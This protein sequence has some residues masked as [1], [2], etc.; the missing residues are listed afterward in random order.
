MNALWLP[1]V[2][3]GPIAAVTADKPL[4]WLRNGGLEQPAGWYLQN[5]SLADGGHPGKSLRFDGPGGASQEVLVASAQHT[6][7]AAVD[8]QVAGVAAE[9]GKS[10]YAFAA[11]YQLDEDGQLVAFRDFAQALGAQPWQRHSFTFRVDPR[12]VHVSLRCGLHQ[13]TGTACFDNWTLVLGGKPMRLDEVQEIP[14][15]PARPGSAAILS[16]ADLPVRGKPSSPQALAKILQGAGYQTQLLSAEDIADPT[17]FNASR[18]DLLV[19][20]TGP[21]FPAEARLATVDFLRK[22]GNLLTTGGYAFQHL[23]RKVG[24]RWLSEEE[25]AKLRL[26]EALQKQS[27]LPNGGFEKARDLP[28]GGSATD[29]QWRRASDRCTV[30]EEDPKE[31]RFVAKVDL[32][33]DVPDPG[34]HAWLDLP[35]EPGKTYRISG[36]MRTR[37]V[38]GAG[39]AFIAIYQHDAAGKLVEHRDFASTRGTTPWQFYT[40]VFTPKPQVARLH[41]FFG[42]YLAHGTAWFDDIRLVETTGLQFR[43]MNTSTGKPGDGLAVAPTQIGIFDPSFP[44]KR[45][46]KIRTAPD[47]HVLREA[48][49]H[50]PHP[51]PLPQGEGTVSGWAASG[52][53]GYDN[54]RWVP[55]LETFDR[56]GRP[57]GAAGAM[58]LHYNGPFAGSFWAY[59]GA[60]NVDL[61]AETDGPAARGLQQ[62]ARFMLRKTF[63]HNL[64]TDH[65]LYR[66]DE[67]VR[68]AVVVDNHGTQEFRGAVR[69]ELFA[70]DV[71]QAASLPVGNTAASWQLALRAVVRNVVVGPNSTQRVEAVLEKF[72]PRPDVCRL[73]ATLLATASPV[74]QVVVRPSRLHQ[75]AG[76]TPAPQAAGSASSDHGV[77]ID[78]MVS[79]IVFEQPAVLQSGPQLRFRDNYFTLNGRPTFLF[80]SDTYALVYKAACENPWTW[81]QELATARDVGMNLYENLQYQNPGHR[82]TEDD[83]RAF[84]A[85][86]QLAQRSGLVFMPGML[87]GHNVAIGDTALE[88]E[89]RLCREYASRLGSTPGLLWYINGDYQLDAAGRPAEVKTLWNRWLKTEHGTTERLRSRWGAAAVQGELGNLEYPPPNSGRWDDAAAVDRMRLLVWLMRRWN[90]A[91]VAA[92]RQHDREHP[93]TSEYYSF[94]FGGM[95]LVM[96]IDGQDVSNIGYFDRPGADLDGLPLKIRW[97]DLRL[98]GK[99][100]S[101]GEYGVKTHP[102]WSEANGGEGYHIVRSEEEQSQLFL[103]VAHYGLGLGACKIQNWCLRDDPTWVFPWGIFYPNHLVPKDVA[104]AHRNQSVLWRFFRPVFRPETL[105]VCIA[106]QLRLGNDDGLGTRVGYQAFADLLALHYQFNVIDDDHLDKLAPQIKTMILPCPLS[107]R[108][109]AFEKLMGWVKAGGTLFATGDFTHDQYRR[110]TRSDRLKQLAGVELVA[111]NGQAGSRTSAKEAR[112]N[113]PGLGI[114][115]AVVRSPDRTTPPTEGLQGSGDLRSANRRGQETCAER[116]FLGPLTLRPCLRIK[117]LTAEVLGKAS[118]GEPVLVRHALGNGTVYFLTDPIEMAD[119]E[120]TIAARRQL[121]A[122]VLRAASRN[123]RASPLPLTVAPDEPWL[124]V[125][126]QPTARGTV[127]VIYNKKPEPGTATVRISTAAG[128]VTLNT[129]NRWPALAAVTASGAVVAVNA[130]GKASVGGKPLLEGAGLKALLSL[131][132]NDLRTA[133]AILIAPF[134]PGRAGLPRRTEP[135]VALVG[136]FREGRWRTLEQIALDSANPTL[137]IDADRATCLILVCPAAQS[138]RWTDRLTQAML[139]PDQIAGY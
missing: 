51:S 78:A 77:P 100:V 86:A 133:T 66:K 69:F 9:P 1:I 42:F 71:G 98:R 129:R 13:A 6:L 38:N 131:D 122:A 72:A 102:A 96:S 37:D 94:P 116:V 25:L 56:Y 48:V 58:L 82:M 23:V 15:R 35:A 67:P 99:G 61:W 29:G 106:N 10:G 54:A 53:V 89:S 105:A 80:G 57:R 68:A 139:R 136:E 117:P 76:E 113:F 40:H 75:T 121:Y 50:S 52:L 83:W 34:A 135:S 43:P 24:D 14:P 4:S 119:D 2:L 125:M 11:V 30:V 124:H 20:P 17:V 62:I 49:E 16:H 115:R 12:T 138:Q 111:A 104:Y 45:A 7:T 36:W 123:H 137:E 39:I 132:G 130:Y 59:F 81:H 63:L 134:E 85:M 128:P 27:L 73:T 92:V 28:I 65:R 60:E 3:V 70:P 90:E 91:H 22:G 64:A 31:G 26:Q 95:D 114:G 19:A 120:P 18:Y 97:N 112:A 5:G 33:Q 88:E 101:L 74:G 127:H 109:D 103:A 126:S 93:I 32:P 79:G 87:I 108:D 8:V 46:R 47:Q 84:G 55:L 44:L 107:M 110:R 41:V 118:D 21:T